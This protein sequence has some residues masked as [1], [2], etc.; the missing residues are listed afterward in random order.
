MGCLRIL[1]ITVLCCLSA[2]LGI[3]Q[4]LGDLA[5]QQQDKKGTQSKARHV[6]TDDDLKS[7]S[8]PPASSS[9][10]SDSL[11]KDKAPS[12]QSSA[13]ADASARSA[14][15]LQAR[16]KDQKQRI[17]DVEAY[18]KDIEKQME[19]WKTSDCTH[20]VYTDSQRNACDQPQKLTA[21]YERAKQRLKTEQA[22]LEDIQEQARRLGYGNSFYDPR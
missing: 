19:P 11:K 5:R 14:A 7:P 18:M 10:S 8:S 12:P 16:I 20:I 15:E 22:N 17:A 6:I 3:A 21:E 4:S 2:S 9:G 13:S 1:T